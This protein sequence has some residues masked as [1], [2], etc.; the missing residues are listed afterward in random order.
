[1]FRRLTEGPP[2][3]RPS[4]FNAILSRINAWRWSFRMIVGDG[5]VLA[6]VN[7]RLG[8]V[9]ETGYELVPLGA[10]DRQALWAGSTPF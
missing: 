8:K 3:G 6:V 10:I 9:F 7:P 4:F 5:R 2:P 1:M